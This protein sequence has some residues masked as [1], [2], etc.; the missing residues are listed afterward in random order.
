[1]KASTEP[2]RAVDALCLG[3]VQRSRRREEVRDVAGRVVGDCSV[4][5]AVFI[6][7]QIV[8]LRQAPSLSLSRR[9]ELLAVAAQHH[10]AATI[11]GLDRAAYAALVVDVTGLHEQVVANSVATVAH[12]LR[13][14]RGILQAATSAGA[15]WDS[16]DAAAAA[17][18]SLFSR[19]G[20]VVAFVTAGNGPGVHGLWPQAVAM[21]YRVLVRPSSREPFTAQ[22]LVRALQ[23]AGLEGYVALLPTDH[24]GAETL[25][26]QSDL[27]VVYGGPD[28]VKR[29]GSDPRVLVQGPGR[30]KI[31][32]GK[33]VGHDEALAVVAQSILSLGG[34]ACV[35][36]SAVLVEHDAGAFAAKLKL[37]LAR[38]TQDRP[39]RLGSR[40]EAEAYERLLA[41][42]DEPWS[43][44][45][46]A[47]SGVP[48][49]PHVA[50]VERASDPRIQRELP[51]PCVTVA[52]FD[53]Q[54][55]GAALAGSLVV[56]V[57]SRQA[58]LIHSVL[59]D[60]S[61]ANVY[62]GNVP[63]TWMDY[64][65]PHDGYLADFLMRNRGIRIEPG[66]S[67]PLE[68]GV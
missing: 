45:R 10:E 25:I 16:S 36:A 7:D 26:E 53:R 4:M 23:L 12:G 13:N 30:S 11:E 3:G 47:T 46:Q 54:S 61:I 48:L 65:V 40:Q 20:D 34:A 64:R 60:A 35:S 24:K 15:V 37:E 56:T 55:G 28:V 32:V 51:F 62:V 67:T 33:D 9:L 44:D 31:V 59:A 27:A 43:F 19:R 14:M 6:Q 18:C 38:R 5:P 29:Y 21:G 50:F 63:T 57:V 68:S 39:A 58:D 17:G 1:M 42:D 66:W 8:E 49:S 2:L 52:P 41:S 22:R